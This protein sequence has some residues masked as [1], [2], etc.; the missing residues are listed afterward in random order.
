[1][2]DDFILNYNYVV[3]PLNGTTNSMLVKTTTKEGYY[4]IDQTAKDVF[5]T[6][7][8]VPTFLI[9]PSPEIIRTNNVINRKVSWVL[10]FKLNK[11]TVP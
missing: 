5:I 1:M 2:Y 3:D 10:S 7:P 8:L 6:P 11:N 4:F 9:L